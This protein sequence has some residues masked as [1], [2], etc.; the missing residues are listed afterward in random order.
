MVIK[1]ASE[2]NCMVGKEQMIVPQIAVCDLTPSDLKV[3][4]W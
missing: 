4:A 3:G 1:A 2:P